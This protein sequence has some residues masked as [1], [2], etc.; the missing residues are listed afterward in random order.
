MSEQQTPNAGAEGQQQQ[1]PAG[2][3]PAGDKTFNQAEVDRIVAE[4]LRR[5]REK[6][7]DVEDLRKKAARLDEL[8]ASQKSELEK[9]TEKTAEAERRAQTA[10]AALK[11][12]RTRNAIARAAVKAN[13]IDPDD[14]AALIDHAS[15]EYDRDDEPSNLD[16]LLAALAKSKPHLISEAPPAT[17]G[18]GD[19]GPRGSAPATKD[20]AQMFGDA[21]AS[22]LGR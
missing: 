20:P 12:E 21:V 17:P 3:P 6:T 19:G 1:P 11:T 22:R 7:G 8:E 13:F 2:D 14:A 16:K 4:R 15:I 5:E 18:S 9:A 10:E